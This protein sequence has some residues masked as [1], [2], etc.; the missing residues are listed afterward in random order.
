MVGDL[1]VTHS[2]TVINSLGCRIAAFE[3]PRHWPHLASTSVQPAT[4]NGWFSLGQSLKAIDPRFYHTKVEL[5][6]HPTPLL[7]GRSRLARAGIHHEGDRRNAA[8]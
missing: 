4:R 3:L 5:N 7:G 6:G 8:R 1:L 2:E